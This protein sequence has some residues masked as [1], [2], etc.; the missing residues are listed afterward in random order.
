VLGVAAAVGLALYRP[1]V[2][3]PFGVDDFSE[4][5][6][7]LKGNATFAGRVRAMSAYY[8]HHGRYNLVACLAV[9]SKWEL[10]G[11][12]PRLWQL[13]RA[14]QMIA[15]VP[16]AFALLRRL[17]RS[18]LASGAG[19]ALLLLGTGASAGWT[20]LTTGEPLATL[21]LL[22]GGHCALAVQRTARHW[23]ARALT[24]AAA[25]VTIVLTKEA[26][27][28]LVPFVVILL[29]ARPSAGAW[30]PAPGSGRRVAVALG[31][32][33]AAVAL[34][35]VP[36]A[37]TLLR[38]RSGGGYISNY[39]A[40]HVGAGAF[41]RSLAVM[42]LPIRLDT[43]VAPGL[44]GAALMGDALY[45]LVVIGGWTA[46]V[47]AAGRRALVALAAA[48]WLPVALAVVYLPWLEVLDFYLLPAL[49]GDALLLAFA[50][51]FVAERAPVLRKSAVAACA[52]TCAA[53]ALVAFQHARAS[54]A[55]RIVDGRVVAA[56]AELAAR[57]PV[58]VARPRDMLPPPSNQWM[59]KGPVLGRDAAVLFDRSLRPVT[60]VACEAAPDAVAHGVPV[61]VYS[62]E[63]RRAPSPRAVA[64]RSY[65]RY[66]DLHRLS[67]ATD[68]AQADLFLPGAPAP[69]P[70][71]SDAPPRRQPAAE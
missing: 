58:V 11:A 39:N 5:L 22:V 29:A 34:A 21:C 35:S 70:P 65:Y 6:A 27:V 48:L 18:V 3:V 2:R 10:F 63:C 62:A 40:T 59:G 4:F 13:A 17:G 53:A 16:A 45:A 1:W 33:C 46:G 55:K 36:V 52:L 44:R 54:E 60:D 38:A 68:S 8:Q 50:L 67:V 64:V 9:V 47:R 28:V 30:T 69:P 15:I 24:I 43:S 61:V 20:W 7:F 19:A 12:D 14:A 66:L 42:L 57:T 31:V 23:V 41:A 26:L 71:P 51:D 25:A 56:V 32:L 37:L 49:L